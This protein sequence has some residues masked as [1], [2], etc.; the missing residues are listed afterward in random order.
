MPQ[1]GNMPLEQIIEFHMQK[2]SLLRTDFKT[3]FDNC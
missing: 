2:Y 3:S 1:V